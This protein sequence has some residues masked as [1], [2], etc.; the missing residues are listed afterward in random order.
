MKKSKIVID[1]HFIID[2]I[3]RNI[4]GSFVEQMG[5]SIYE[6]I[7]YPGSPFADEDGFRKDVIKL[8]SELNIPIIRYPG[9]N[10]VSGFIWEDSVGPKM[11]VRQ[12]WN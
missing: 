7:Y 2:K 3:D 4:Y 6:G 11:N 5:R 9:G 12:D 10:F 1:R 8:V